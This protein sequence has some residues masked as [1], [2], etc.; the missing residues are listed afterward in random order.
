[1]SQELETYLQEIGRYK[2]LSQKELENLFARYS[3]NGDKSAFEKIICHNLKLVVSIAKKY[4][5]I[6]GDDI[7][8]NDLIQ[9][10]NIGL[11]KGAHKFRPELG[12]KFSTYVHYWIEQAIRRAIFNNYGIHIPANKIELIQKVEAKTAEILEQT[13]RIPQDE[14]IAIEL[15]LTVEDIR[16]SR[17][18]PHFLYHLDKSVN[19]DEESEQTNFDNIVDTNPKK[20]PEQTHLNE[21]KH[22]LVE[23]ILNL[24]GKREKYV[25]MLR[26]GLKDS[27]CYSLKEI[28]TKLNIT[29]ERVRQI[30][31]KAA[32]KIKGYGI[33]HTYIIR[34]LKHVFAQE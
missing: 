27:K 13:G 6:Y 9:E 26:Y 11:I 1:M 3:N 23:H 20:S 29:R 12:Y 18:I 19:E 32:N 22:E 28:A 8:L 14:Q 4:H 33:S 30:E 24:L 34:T 31:M 25:L 2:V 7:S 15:G 17:M 5:Q 10:G 16:N 21:I